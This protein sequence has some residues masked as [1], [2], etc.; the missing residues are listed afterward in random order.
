MMLHTPGPVAVLPPTP[1]A[2]PTVPVF[3]PPPAAALPPALLPPLSLL[4]SAH[5]ANANTRDRLTR[6]E[7]AKRCA[8][9]RILMGSSYFEM[10]QISEARAERPPHPNA[11]V[12]HWTTLRSSVL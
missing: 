12:L 8:E 1:V 9:G 10:D 11:S 6:V 5:P 2:P 3:V 7:R 4:D